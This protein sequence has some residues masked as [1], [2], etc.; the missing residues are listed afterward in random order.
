MDGH[1]GFVSKFD[2]L[3]CAFKAP[4]EL[5]RVA[6]TLHGPPRGRT[7]LRF[8]PFRSKSNATITNLED[9]SG[10]WM[11]AVAAASELRRRGT[12]I[13]PVVIPGLVPPVFSWTRIVIQ[14]ADSVRRAIEMTVSDPAR[15]EVLHNFD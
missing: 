5:S 9:Q 10:S 3:Q 7:L 4:G 2:R 1:V 6:R 12:H 14:F 11:S 15:Y 13:Q 8:K